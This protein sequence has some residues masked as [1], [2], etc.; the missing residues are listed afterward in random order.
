MN[1]KDVVLPTHRRSPEAV[2]VAVAD[3]VTGDG[4][5][6]SKGKGSD[7]KEASH[8]NKDSRLYKGE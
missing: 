2:A 6:G 5:N 1:L 3:D 7:A 4:R 8:R